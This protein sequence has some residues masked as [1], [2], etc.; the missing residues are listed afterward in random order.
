MTKKRIV[1][2]WDKLVASL[3]AEY[4]DMT[5]ILWTDYGDAIRRGHKSQTFIGSKKEVAKQWHTDSLY[6]IAR[7]ADKAAYVGKPPRFRRYIN[8]TLAQIIWQANNDADFTTHIIQ[9]GKEKESP[10]QV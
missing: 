7:K 4:L 9:Q 2:K 6:T 3:P 5:G 10:V 8:L 1:F